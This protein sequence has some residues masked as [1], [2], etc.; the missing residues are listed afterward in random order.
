[1][2]VFYPRRC[3]DDCR[4]DDGQ[5]D[6]RQY[7]NGLLTA[8]QEEAIESSFEYGDFYDYWRYTMADGTVYEYTESNE[9][10]IPYS[11][12]KIEAEGGDE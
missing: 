12:E 5:E 3:P 9:Y 6:K 2:K 1:M 10:G 7:F 11:I 4:E 8:I